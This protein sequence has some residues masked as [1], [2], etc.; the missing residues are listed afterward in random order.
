[1]C[2][3]F[4]L[5]EPV[6]EVARL[7]GFDVADVATGGEGRRRFN[8][9]PGTPVLAVAAGAGGGR[10]GLWL[11]WGLVPAWARDVR[12]A[13][14]TFNARA[15]GVAA[16]PAFRTAF[17]RRRCLVPASAFYE[18]EAKATAGGRRQPYAF[19]AAAGGPLALGGVWD[20]N[21]HVVAGSTLRTLAVVTTAASGAVARLHDRMPLILAPD[22]W[23]LWLDPG[24]P[25][26]DVSTLL[27]PAPADALVAYPVTTRVNDSAFEDP[28][29]LEPLAAPP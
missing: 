24:A 2:G 25:V 5:V 28:A 8:I 11:R 10:R 1:V 29:C 12:V 23:A 13:A 21:R 17:A 18:W 3:R 4:A 20:E 6:P 14:R 9:A 19:R 15:E 7:F 26:A 22:A 16:R 27:R